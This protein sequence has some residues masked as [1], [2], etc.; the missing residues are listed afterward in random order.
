M[1]PVSAKPALLITHSKVAY[2]VLPVDGSSPLSYRFPLPCMSLI[3]LRAAVHLCPSVSFSPWWPRTPFSLSCSVGSY[4][5]CPYRRA[6]SPPP[7]YF[8]TFAG[9]GSLSS[10]L[11]VSLYPLWFLLL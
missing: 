8:L 1:S 9:E 7:S 11:C 2:T 3:M 10:L 4:L 6:S 5:G